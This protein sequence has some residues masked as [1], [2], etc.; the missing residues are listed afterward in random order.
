[1]RKFVVAAA[2]S[3]S[4]LLLAP[5]GAS[6]AVD[7]EP[8]APS[9][10]STSYTPDNPDEPTLA[11]SFAVGECE[12]DV[13]WI[14]YNVTLTDPDNQ[15]TSDEVYLVITDGVNTVEIFLGT[16]VD[17]QLSGR[18]LWPGASVDDN[19]VANGWP[20][21]AFENGEWIEIDGN[22]AWT[23]GDITAFIRVNPDIAVALSY[24]PATPL[25]DANPRNPSTAGVLSSTG[26]SD[27]VLPTAIIGG[28]VLAA[29]LSLFVLRRRPRN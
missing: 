8:P 23:R 7:P 5:V 27:L 29:G 21:W 3:A 14:S 15:S 28:L 2:L 22:F 13:P 24:P 17:N 6:A 4:L 12:S 25:C 10:T 20:G 26:M 18:I 11:G 19:G 1:M 9:P 16:L